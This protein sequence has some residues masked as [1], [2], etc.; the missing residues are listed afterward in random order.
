MSKEAPAPACATDAVLVQSV[1]MP[2][3]TPI[4]QG[5]DFSKGRDL[6]SLLSAMYTTGYQARAPQVPRPSIRTRIRTEAARPQATSFGQCINEVNRMLRW[7]LSDDP[8]PADADTPW[9][10]PEVREKTDALV[11]L[12][13]AG[14][15]P[16]RTQP[17]V[18]PAPLWIKSVPLLARLQQGYT[19][20]LISSGVRETL[21]YL[22]QNRMV[23]V[24]V[25]TAGGIEEDFIKC[26]APT[27]LGDFHVSCREGGVRRKTSMRAA[28]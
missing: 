8:M 24:I 2:Q 13:R 5:H 4:V 10:D 28:T 23:D 1:E 9:N 26:M 21:R 22:A 3:D 7:R 27:Y 25:T 17:P 15:V 12:V 16:L 19:S 14:V 11:F 18:H 20:N 6:D